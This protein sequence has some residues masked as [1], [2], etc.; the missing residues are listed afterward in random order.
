MSLNNLQV[1]LQILPL[2]QHYSN[3]NNN[4]T[5]QSIVKVSENQVILSAIPNA[6]IFPFT[7]VLDINTQQDQH[8]HF[9]FDTIP[10]STINE[11]IQGK[12][13]S[14]VVYDSSSNNRFDTKTLLAFSDLFNLGLPQY[15][16]FIKFIES[17]GRDLISRDGTEREYQVDNIDI[18]E[19]YYKFGLEQRKSGIMSIFSIILKQP[20]STSQLNIMDLTGCDHATLDLFAEICINNYREPAMPES[21]EKRFNPSS[22]IFRTLQSSSSILVIACVSYLDNIAQLEHTLSY[23]S[24]IYEKTSFRKD[25]TARRSVSSTTLKNRSSQN[26]D[27]EYLRRI[28]L[29]LTNEIN[30]LRHSTYHQRGRGSLN[31]VISSSICSENE[32][33]PRHVSMFSSVSNSTAMTIP[34][35]ISEEKEHML[36]SDLNRQIEELENQITVTRERNTHVERELQDMRSS[37]TQAQLMAIGEKQASIIDHLEW[38][39]AETEKL[40]DDLYQ[41]LVIETETS[42]TMKNKLED[43]IQYIKRGMM[44]LAEDRVLLDKVFRVVENIISRGDKDIYSALHELTLLK[45]HVENQNNELIQKNKEIESLCHSTVDDADIGGNSSDILY[46]QRTQAL[47]SRVEELDEYIEHIRTQRDHYSDQLEERID[48]ADKLQR[49]CA[50]QTAKASGL[51]KKLTEMEEALNSNRKMIRDGDLSGLVQKLENDISRLEKEKSVDEKDF[52]TSY[53]TALNEIETITQRTRYQDEEIQ[54]LKAII[55]KVNEQL[56]LTTNNFNQ[57]KEELLDLQTRF[58]S[59]QEMNLEIKH[60]LQRVVSDRRQQYTHNDHNRKDSI[61]SNRSS[62]NSISSPKKRQYLQRTISAAS[63]N[64]RRSLLTDYQ[65]LDQKEL[66]RWA[67]EKLDDP[68]EG[69]EDV[70]RK[71]AQMSN[72]NAQFALWVGDLETQL[73]SQRHHLAQDIKGLECD[74]MNLT[75]LNNQLEK[76]LEQVSIPVTSRSLNM[77]RCKS[78]NSATEK[79]NN[80]S[81]PTRSGTFSRSNTSSRSSL[82]NHKSKQQQ[83]KKLQNNNRESSEKHISV[84]S[85]ISRWMAGSR[86]MNR[87]VTPINIPPPSDPP[88]NS[89]PPIPVLPQIHTSNS[90]SPLPTTQQNH[91]SINSVLLSNDRNSCLSSCSM[92]SNPCSPI[93]MESYD[94]L[95]RNHLLKITVA[96][97]D[98]KTH[99]QVIHKLESQLADSE[100]KV[101]EQQHEIEALLD[102]HEALEKIKDEVAKTT[103]ELKSERVLKRNAEHAHRILEKRIEE[104][105]D[106]KKSKF[107]CF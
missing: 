6:P 23:I 5:E 95:I 13:T 10:H 101:Q 20:S 57:K 83:Q 59:V 105:M 36:I 22:P 64:R 106:T 68:T 76:E 77:E 72:E 21:T 40:N 55:Q 29:K 18:I 82:N 24:N 14:I 63:D 61:S 78:T 90:T 91:I 50:L 17:G 92:S 9:V 25:T 87:S 69:R 32:H 88:L 31:T 26:D 102:D 49:A 58:D 80:S 28:I 33:G 4:T 99:Q 3:N 11:L 89:I 73:L 84:D 93:T 96:E 56:S 46:I 104:L 2:P 37:S 100:A 74:V 45:S 38:K 107:R 85:E 30:T 71:L 75:V 97:N 7:H 103:N 52:E 12:D 16:V 34:D 43:D 86:S 81:L 94:H 66:L 53:E 51:Q 79:Y 39:L 67:N 70:I 54:R 27:T 19:K 35:P 42:S 47:E 48:E 60:K 15:Q 62:I 98:I 41:K 65:I 1:A 44:D 8:D